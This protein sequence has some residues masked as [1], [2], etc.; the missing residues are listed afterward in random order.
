[1]N[2]PDDSWLE[3]ALTRHIVTIKVYAFYIA[4]V[5]YNLCVE[6]ID[7]S[8]RYMCCQ[9]CCQSQQETGSVHNKYPGE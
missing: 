3:I 8:K 6:K 2:G 5:Y 9:R 7:M 4:A 1:M